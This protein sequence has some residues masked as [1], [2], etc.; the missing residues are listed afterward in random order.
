MLIG[1]YVMKPVDTQVRDRVRERVRSEVDKH[2]V[3]EY[4]IGIRTKH[5]LRNLIWF[6]VYGVLNG[7]D[8]Q[9]SMRG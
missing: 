3:I 5:R 4:N 9:S 7:I 1:C 6:S 8:K 2:D